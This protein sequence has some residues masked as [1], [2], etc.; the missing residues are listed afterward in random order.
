LC[1]LDDHQRSRD[2]SNDQGKNYTG[3]GSLEAAFA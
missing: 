2:D 1:A 3:D